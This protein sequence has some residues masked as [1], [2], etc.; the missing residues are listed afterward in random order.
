MNE[1]SIIVPCLASVEELPEF[2][3]ELAE[4]LMENPGDVETIIVTN[5][6]HHQNISIADYVKKK[7]PWLKF[8]MLQKI[9]PSNS[10]GAIARLGIAYSSSRYAVLV[11]PYGEDDISL[12]GKML[13]LIRN[14]AQVVQATRFTLQKDSETVQLRFR[15]YQYIYRNF[16]KLLLGHNISDSTY[17]FKMFDRVFIQ[18]VGL[19]QTFR[20]I[21]P[22]ITL[23]GL[24]AGGKVEYIPAGIR[25]KQIGSK[26]KLHKDGFG[27][28]WLLLRGL[29]HRIGITWF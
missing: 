24:L 25:P 3:D 29:G 22:E 21:S 23:K 15:I 16:T 4:Y 8:C 5:E 7:Y 11:S 2:M 10:Y 13:S 18:A 12:I 26:F 6:N 28:V 1:L 9:G 27:Y 19:T 20:S 17:A 14:G